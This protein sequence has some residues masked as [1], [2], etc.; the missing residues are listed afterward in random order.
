MTLRDFPP[1]LTKA[2]LDAMEA[3]YPLPTLE[4]GMLTTESERWEM[5]RKQGQH[6]VV[7]EMRGVLNIQKADAA[8]KNSEVLQ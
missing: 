3:K 6:S 5:A 8:K 1:E 4:T 7:R 2:F